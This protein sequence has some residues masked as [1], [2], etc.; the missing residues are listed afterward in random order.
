MKKLI[1]GCLRAVFFISYPILIILLI[2]CAT[3][4][5][6]KVRELNAVNNTFNEAT[7]QL[8]QDNQNKQF[9]IEDLKQEFNKLNEQ[10]ATLTAENDKLKKAQTEGTSTISGKIFPVVSAG[11][12]FSQYQ[13]VCAESTKNTS[14]QFCVTVSGLDQSFT[15]NVPAGAYQVYAELFPKPADQ[16]LADLKAYYTE[17]IKCVAEKSAA[18]CDQTKLTNPVS[19]EVAAGATI[20]NINPI[21]WK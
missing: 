21:D 11:V 7:S 5:F 14:L 12:G 6:I 17:Y 15:L 16:E 1:R 2:V 10:V 18:D 13:R 8:N 20:S 4:L 19:V 9:T 3:V